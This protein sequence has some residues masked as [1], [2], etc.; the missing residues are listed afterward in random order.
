M[1]ENQ[2]NSEDK[3]RYN[4]RVFIIVFI[5]LLLVIQGVKIYLDYQNKR[6]MKAEME[7]KDAELEET[8][9]KLESLSNE[10]QLKIEEIERLGGD[11]S[12]LRTAKENLEQEKKELR[13]SNSILRSRLTRIQDKVEGYE[14]LLKAK[15]EEIAR[16]EDVNEELLS[17]NT[18]L[19]EEKRSLNDS[20][21]KVE[22]SNEEL[23]EKVSKAGRLEAEDIQV[24]GFNWRNKEKIEEEYRNNQI[25]KLKVEFAIAA[26]EVAPIEG[27]D[28]MVRIVEPGNN[29]LF[30]VARGSGTFMYE[31]KE[32]FFTAKKEILYDR[33]R[34]KLSFLYEKGSDY[35]SGEHTVEIY[36]DDYIIGQTSFKVK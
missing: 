12:E 16:L 35:K 22:T 36:A 6:E 19:K 27:K 10:V 29:V 31:G 21:R 18:N 9:N 26:N 1:S 4:I 7:S 2:K 32:R 20:I 3:K 13:N 8:Y 17:E 15:D 24:I 30:D 34:Q 28:I 11:V 25:E 14:E 23:Q 5:S 33:S